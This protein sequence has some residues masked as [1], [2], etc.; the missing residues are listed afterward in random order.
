M[1][2]FSNF[3]TASL[4][5]KDVIEELIAKE[6]APLTDAEIAERLAERGIHVARR[7]VAK[8]RMQLKILPILAAVA[9]ILDA[10][11][12]GQSLKELAFRHLRGPAPKTGAGPLAAFAG[13]PA[14][15]DLNQSDCRLLSVPHASRRNLQ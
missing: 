14:P 3:F 7:T 9:T 6:D 4:S 12:S 2:P 8:Y 10:N 13:G 15:L 1:I 11:A 5:I